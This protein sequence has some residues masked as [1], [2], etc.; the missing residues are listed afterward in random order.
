MGAGCESPRRAVRQ[1]AGCWGPSEDLTGR[2]GIAEPGDRCGG[3]LRVLGRWRIER[4]ALP[5][6]PRPRVRGE[7]AMPFIGDAV[8][9]EVAGREGSIWRLVEPLPHDGRRDSW[10]VDAGVETDFASQSHWSCCLCCS[11]VIRGARG[12]GVGCR[13]GSA[14]ARHRQATGQPTAA[15]PAALTLGHYRRRHPNATSGS[16]APHKWTSTWG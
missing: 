4:S 5:L 12:C 13:C 10:L 16:P 7:R 6:G 1:P 14:T 3:A 11:F 9:W 8:V 15:A 2:L